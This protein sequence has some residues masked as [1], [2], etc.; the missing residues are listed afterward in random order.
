LSRVLSAA[1]PDINWEESG[2]LG[3]NGLLL[4]VN[5][6]QE[7]VRVVVSRQALE[8]YQASDSLNRDFQEKRL[9]SYMRVLRDEGMMAMF[10]GPDHLSPPG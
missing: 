10:I 5:E 9:I 7:R 3:E 4:F 8:L 2:S 1:L 6:R